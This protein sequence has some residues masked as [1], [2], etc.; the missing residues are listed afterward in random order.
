MK[1]GYITQGDPGIFRSLLLPEVADAMSLGVEML[2]LAVTIDDIA[3]GAIAGYIEGSRVLVES[4]YVALE[5]RRQ[6]VGTL[7]VESLIKVTKENAYGMEINFTVTEEEHKHLHPFLCA[8]NFQREDVVDNVTYLTTVGEII[9]RLSVLNLKKQ[10]GV[11]FSDI[12]MN[13]LTSASKEARRTYEQ[14]PEQGFEAETVDKTASMAIVKDEKMVA[15][16]A[17][18]YI[19]EYLMLSALRGDLAN[20]T[21]VA[22][23]FYAAMME[24]KDKY[25]PETKFI[26]QAVRKEGNDILNMVFPTQVEQISFT[27]YHSYYV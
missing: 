26:M 16:V 17:I 14:M 24:I 27:Y 5:Y 13:I 15:Y 19:D 8:M 22:S 20:P 3:V 2:A 6:G 25:A 9:D 18:E 23:L 1:I 11:S 7:L 10:V 21:S 12:D 4:L